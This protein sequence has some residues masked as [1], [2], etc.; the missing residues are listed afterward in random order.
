MPLILRAAKGSKLTIVEMD[1]NLT[2]LASTLSGSIIQVTGSGINASNT[3][4]TS[5]FFVGDGSKLTNV[6]ASFITASNVYGPYGSNS[7]ISASYALSASRAVSSSYANTINPRISGA[8]DLSGSL[9]INGTLIIGGNS[10]TNISNIGGSDKQIQ[11]NNA[12]VF[13]GSSNLTYDYN[14]NTVNLTGSLIATNTGVGSI[15]TSTG[16]LLNQTDQTS[17]DFGRNRLYWPTAGVAVFW[18]LDNEVYLSGLVNIYTGSLTGSLFGT[19]SWAVSSSRAISSSYTL[20]ADTLDGKDSTV[21][22]TTGSNN[23]NGIQAINQGSYLIISGSLNHG[24]LTSIN[25]DPFAYVHAQ[26]LGTQANGTYSHAEGRYAIANGIGSHAEGGASGNSTTS[27]GEGSHA[28]GFGAQSIG[29]FS[30]AHG[31][32]TVSFGPYSFAGGNQTFSSGSYQ[33]VF[34]QFNTRTDSS[35]LFIVGNGTG[36][37]DNVRKDAFK[38][39]HSSSIVVATQSSAP[40]YTGTEGEIVP[41]KN[42]ANYLI[43]VYIGGQWRSSSLL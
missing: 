23:F 41:A 33:T 18:G 30:H 5:S 12:N 34:G 10:I 1:G 16:M 26:G 19:S 24:F 22:A 6:T 35:S 25:T 36:V 38:V 21:F 43:Y 39:T 7:V 40:S 29:N 27:T 28:E 2:Y 15:N 9:S 20:N 14:T 4:I 8:L 31:Y 17:V 37:L 32:Y 13:D 11:F 3:P 42:G